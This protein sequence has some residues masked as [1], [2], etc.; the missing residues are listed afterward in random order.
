[1][2]KKIQDTEEKYTQSFGFSAQEDD[3][4]EEGGEEEGSRQEA[5]RA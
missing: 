1:M 2:K 3:F 5:H 4:Q